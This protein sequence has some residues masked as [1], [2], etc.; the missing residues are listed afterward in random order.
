MMPGRTLHRLAARMCSAK[1]LE[2]MVEPAI[3]DLQKEYAE[4]G[5]TD[6]T[7]RIWTVIT[8]Y[9]AILKVIAMCAL[10]VSDATDDEWRA[11]VGVLAWSAAMFLVV[12]V[13]LILLPFASFDD[14]IRS[15]YAAATLV[16]QAVPLAIPIA[17]AFGLALGLRARTTVS[18]AKIMLVC[19]LA[20]SLSSFATLAWV[21][22]ASN[23]AFREMTLREELK[24]SGDVETFKPP[25]KAYNEMSLTELRREIAQLSARDEP[26]R[27]R[28]YAH[29]FHLRFS[30]AAATLALA[31]FLLAAPVN[32]RALRTLIA[33][34]ACLAYW[35]LIYT[36]EALSVYR[37]AIPAFVGAWLPNIVFAASAILIVSSRSSRLRGLLSPA[38]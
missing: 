35:A 5:A 33:F 32:H 22:P 6:H 10:R 17:V 38:K 1:T 25:P 30:L 9:A 21:M 12:A 26:G 23:Q 27:A 13:L 18:V 28:Q 15:W 3:A 19:A 2:R 14:R 36:G 29:R 11:I 24:A 34:A 16:P 7:R 4:A 37:P 31:I 20:A 8:G